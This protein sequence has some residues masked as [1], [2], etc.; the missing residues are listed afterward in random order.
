MFMYIGIQMSN[1]LTMFRQ[2]LCRATNYKLKLNWGEIYV[3]NFK[4]PLRMGR[5]FF[6]FSFFFFFF[7]PSLLYK[8]LLWVTFDE[9]RGFNRS[10]FLLQLVFLG[11]VS[12]IYRVEKNCCLLT[13]KTTV[14]WQWGEFGQVLNG[15][16]G[17]LYKL[18]DWKTAERWPMLIYFW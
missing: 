7:S 8:R 3:A 13:L 16:L 6:L 17:H 10:C 15:Q 9:G 5:V 1:N 2:I 18:G 12:C 4:A 14:P 11:S